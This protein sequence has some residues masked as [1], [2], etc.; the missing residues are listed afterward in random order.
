MKD[1]NID[2]GSVIVEGQVFSVDHRELKKRNA[3]IVSFDMT[4]NTSSVRAPAGSWKT[5]RPNPFWTIVQVGT[6]L[7]VQGRSEL[8]GTRAK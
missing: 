8:I 4:D 2:M 5:A 3:W 7:R 6:I 1:L